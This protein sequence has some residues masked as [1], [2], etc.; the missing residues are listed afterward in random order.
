MTRT[1][2]VTKTVAK[3]ETENLFLNSNSQKTLPYVSRE[4]ISEVSYC[5]RFPFSKASSVEAL[6]ENLPGFRERTNSSRMSKAC[7]MQKIQHCY[8]LSHTKL[9]WMFL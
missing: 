5:A 1:V 8:P 7:K 6:E 2:T 9:T 4:D 3:H